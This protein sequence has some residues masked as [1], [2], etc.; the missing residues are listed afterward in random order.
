MSQAL[1]LP[2]YNFIRTLWLLHGFS[3]HPKEHTDDDIKN[4]GCQLT[5]VLLL[6]KT[7]T[8]L[9]QVKFS[10]NTDSHKERY[11]FKHAKQKAKGLLYPFFN[12]TV[13]KE[14]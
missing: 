9:F 5:S 11:I 6:F 7:G 10:L 8:G 1:H 2:K 13:N 4:T 3:L 14:V 12:V